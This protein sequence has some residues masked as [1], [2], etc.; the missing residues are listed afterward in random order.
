M[1]L[2]KL[3]TD[4]VLNARAGGGVGGG[5]GGG[6]GVGGGEHPPTSSSAVDVENEDGGILRERLLS[7]LEER[8]VDNGVRLLAALPDG[9]MA[10]VL[11]AIEW[12]DERKR[13]SSRVGVGLLVNCIREG[14][15]P[16]FQ[17]QA[18][19]SD[20]KLPVTPRLLTAVRG[21]CL[22]PDGCRRSEVHDM[23]EEAAGRRGVTA[24]E[25][26]SQAMGPRWDL[27][28]PHPGLIY[29]MPGQARRYNDMLGERL[30]PDA[31]V[32]R[33]EGEPVLGWAS[34][35]WRIETSGG[36]K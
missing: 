13:A 15:K 22:S 10:A 32:V 1:T 29:S 24:D 7:M 3:R 20:R 8:D 28:P 14:G 17:S 11:G 5:G 19:R 31:T 34:R 35:F 6:G 4:S 33:G 12:W 18:S 9:E 27:T 36:S 21:R 30:R 25:L 2:E 26:V 23:F 16:G